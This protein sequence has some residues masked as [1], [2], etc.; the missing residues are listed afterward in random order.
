MLIYQV[1]IIPFSQFGLTKSCIV[2]WQWATNTWDILSEQNQKRRIVYSQK[3]IKF[4]VSENSRYVLPHIL[5][6][7]GYEVDQNLPAEEKL[8]DLDSSNPLA[9]ISCYEETGGRL[10][11]AI[12]FHD[13]NNNDSCSSYILLR[14]ALSL[15]TLLPTH[16]SSYD[17]SPNMLDDDQV[18]I[19]E[20]D[21]ED[22]YTPNGQLQ[23]DEEK[24]E[25]VEVG[26]DEE[27]EERSNM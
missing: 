8:A 13:T 5:S 2:C 17:H 7:Q 12:I 19:G 10:S 1:G 18:N 16:G 26:N 6:T 15:P 24:Q 3:A 23:E 20:D 4:K 25:I 22:L 21:K 14:Q 27:G 11:E 9:N